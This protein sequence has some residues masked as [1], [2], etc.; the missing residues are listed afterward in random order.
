M[1]GPKQVLPLRVCVNLRVIVMNGYS[2]FA[3]APRLGLLHQMFKY[4]ILDTC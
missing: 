2:S 3:K 4:H 1:M